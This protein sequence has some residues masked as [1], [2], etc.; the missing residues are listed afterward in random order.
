VHMKHLEEEVAR[1]KEL[2]ERNVTEN[3]EI[4][5]DVRSVQSTVKKAAIS[6][7]ALLAV[8]IGLVV[9]LL[10]RGFRLH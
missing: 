2:H 6:V 1:A 5:E 4:V 10:V 9:W 8:L 3:L 7:G